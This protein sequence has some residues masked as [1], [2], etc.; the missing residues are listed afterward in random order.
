MFWGLTPALDLLKELEDH[1]G[2]LPEE[3]NILI[4]GG[5]DARHVLQTVAKRY[6]HKSPKINFYL[7]EACVETVAK[8]LLLLNIALQ[9]DN[10]LGLEQKTKVFME[11][12]GNT[13]VRPSVAKYLASVAHELVK[14]VT[15]YDYLNKLMSCVTLDI[16]YKERDYLEN[17]LKFW[18]GKEEFDIC[19]SWDR[20]LRNFLGVR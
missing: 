14:M 12:Y 9:P 3:I 16:K 1:D 5:A 19:R 7:A 15:N 2:N 6:R 13:M 18:C 4:V 17:L 20:R 8:Q 10:V 11:L